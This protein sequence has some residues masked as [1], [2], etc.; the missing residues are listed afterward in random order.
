MRDE[1]GEM[2]DERGEMRDER[3]GMR[4]YA[5]IG[6]GCISGAK[7]PRLSA[8]PSKVFNNWSVDRDRE[9]YRIEKT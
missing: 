1:R 8:F 2:R 5:R 9:V 7:L 6:A 3:G 4:G